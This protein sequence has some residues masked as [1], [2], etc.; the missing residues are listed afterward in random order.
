MK[1]VV[2]FIFFIW[3]VL[4]FGHLLSRVSRIANELEKCKMVQIGLQ[5]QLD[6]VKAQLGAQH[7]EP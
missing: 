1:Y 4:T 2:E 3:I 5:K 7:G 6:D